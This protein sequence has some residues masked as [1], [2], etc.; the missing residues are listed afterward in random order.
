[1][2]RQGTGIV[3][4]FD[5]GDVWVL[6]ELV[7]SVTQLLDRGGPAD[8]ADP[9]D[10]ALARLLPDGLRDE[11]EAARQFRE[12]TEESVREYKAD[13]ARRMLDS[14]PSGGGEVRLDR[15]ST[16]AWLSAL[17]DVRLVVGTRLGVTQDWEMPG[18]DGPAVAGYGLYRWLAALQEMLVEAAMDVPPAT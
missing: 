12:L 2:G 11:P 7:G 16:R 9:A 13:T 8:P 14:L 5:P 18:T 17:N 3:L 4:R 6:R 1:M 10:P 15:E